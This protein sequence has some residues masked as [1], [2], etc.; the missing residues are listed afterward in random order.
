MMHSTRWNGGKAMKWSIQHFHKSLLTFSVSLQCQWNQK[1]CLVGITKFDKG[2]ISRCN[3]TIT[4]LRSCL[5]VTTVEVIE[6]LH[7]QVKAGLVQGVLESL[8]VDDDVIDDGEE[9][10]EEDLYR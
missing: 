1:A 6:Y 2:L 4:D 10:D 5:N 7:W 9:V 8:M 3:L